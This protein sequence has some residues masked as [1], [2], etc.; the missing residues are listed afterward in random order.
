YDDCSFQIFE[1]TGND[2]GATRA[3]AIG[4]DRHRQSKSLFASGIGKI[5]APLSRIPALRIRDSSARRE[6]QSTNVNCARQKASRVEAQIHDQ[7]LHP[8]C[9]QVV[10]LL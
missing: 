3:Q 2:L 1:R 6:E 10:K 8:L 7:R 9:L 5:L 4:E